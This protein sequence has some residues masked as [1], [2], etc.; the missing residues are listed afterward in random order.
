MCSWLHCV[1]VAMHRLSLIGVSGGYSVATVCGLLIA[2][3]SVFV[4]HGLQAR[5]LQ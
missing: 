1:F 3:A 2:V 4:G 5:V